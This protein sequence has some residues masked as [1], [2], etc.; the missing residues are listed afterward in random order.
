MTFVELRL[1]ARPVF[2]RI[3]KDFVLGKV[4]MMLVKVVS[5]DHV[6]HFPLY[7]WVHAKWTEVNPPPP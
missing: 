1:S 7:K 2:V 6:I 3:K 5:R 4:Q